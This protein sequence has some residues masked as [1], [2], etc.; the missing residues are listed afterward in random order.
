MRSFLLRAA[1]LL[2]CVVGQDAI[3]QAAPPSNIFAD[4]EAPSPCAITPP[5]QPCI[6]VMRP[7]KLDA[8]IL[9][10]EI[11]TGRLTFVNTLNSVDD[12]YLPAGRYETQLLYHSAMQGYTASSYKL[13]PQTIDVDLL[14]N[15]Q[16]SQF[17]ARFKISRKPKMERD[18]AFHALSGTSKLK[19]QVPQ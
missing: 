7:V 5:E 12:L 11:T 15:G 13:S 3:A 18:V 8:M 4:V 16:L 17:L 19:L 14:P 2:S 6:A 1:T 9:L 10:R